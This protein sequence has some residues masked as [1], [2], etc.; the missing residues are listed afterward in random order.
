VKKQ[1]VLSSDMCS[2]YGKR[3]AAGEQQV[4]EN[5]GRSEQSFIPGPVRSQESYSQCHQYSGCDF[6]SLVD[7]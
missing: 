3:P 2:S 5:E 1:L 7:L 4:I 6:A